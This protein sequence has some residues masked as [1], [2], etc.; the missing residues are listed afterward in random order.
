[1][2]VSPTIDVAYDGEC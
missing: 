2:L 1:M